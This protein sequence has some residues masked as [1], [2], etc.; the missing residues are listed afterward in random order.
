MPSPAENA[1]LLAN[2]ALRD[3]LV[4][5]FSVADA[6]GS[7][8]ST[9]VHGSGGLIQAA[10]LLLTAMVDAT[11]RFEAFVDL[12]GAVNQ[13]EG[14]VSMQTSTEFRQA[15]ARTLESVLTTV[16]ANSMFTPRFLDEVLLSAEGPGGKGQIPDEELRTELHEYIRRWRALRSD[17]VSDAASPAAAAQS[18]VGRS[19]AD[20]DVVRTSPVRAAIPEAPSHSLQPSQASQSSDAPVLAAQQ[21]AGRLDSRVMHTVATALESV[22]L[23]VGDTLRV[24]TPGPGVAALRGVGDPSSTATDQPDRPDHSDPH[25]QEVGRDERSFHLSGVTPPL[26]QVTHTEASDTVSTGTPGVP[27]ED[28]PPNVPL[29]FRTWALPTYE[30]VYSTFETHVRDEPPGLLRKTAGL[31]CS[32]K[33]LDYFLSAFAR[34]VPKSVCGAPLSLEAAFKCTTCSTDNYAVWCAD[35]FDAALHEGHC[36]RLIFASGLCDCGYSQT[37]DDTGFCREHYGNRCQFGLSDFSDSPDSPD[38]PDREAFDA[39]SSRLSEARAQYLAALRLV[40]LDTFAG[41]ALILLVLTVFV[42]AVP[43]SGLQLG[44]A[45]YHAKLKAYEHCRT[46]I[47]SVFDIVFCSA[48]STN[49]V[50]RKLIARLLISPYDEA[51][52][53][54]DICHHR[55]S[56]EHLVGLMDTDVCSAALSRILDVHTLITTPPPFSA[57]L[58]SHEFLKPYH[59][60]I[61]LAPAPEGSVVWSIRRSLEHL[62][63]LAGSLE[64]EFSLGMGLLFSGEAPVYLLFCMSLL[65]RLEESWISGVSEK[66]YGTGI[67]RIGK[68]AHRGDDFSSGSEEAAADEI[69][70]EEITAEEWPSRRGI[71]PLVE[72]ME[73]FTEAVDSQGFQK[74]MTFLCSGLV[75]EPEYRAF[76]MYIEHW[77][78]RLESLTSFYPSSLII[79]PMPRELLA[80]IGAQ[81]AR[82]ELRQTM[83]QD[84]VKAMIVQKTYQISVTRLRADAAARAVLLGYRLPQAERPAYDCR[85]VLATMYDEGYSMLLDQLSLWPG[86][87][88][89][90]FSQMVGNAADLL[91]FIPPQRVFETAL[92]SL[93]SQVYNTIAIPPHRETDCIT[94]FL[95]MTSC[96]LASLAGKYPVASEV[97]QRYLGSASALATLARRLGV[98]ASVFRREV[99]SEERRDIR[100]VDE[101]MGTPDSTGLDGLL[102]TAPGSP[103]HPSPGEPT[104]Y[105][106]QLPVYLPARSG[107]STHF[108]RR[109][110]VLRLAG[111]NSPIQF[112]GKVLSMSLAIL[113][114]PLACLA[115][116]LLLMQFSAGVNFCVTEG[117]HI[118]NASRIFHNAYSLITA[119]SSFT[120]NTLYGIWLSI[121]LG[122]FPLPGAG[123]ASQS[124][125]TQQQSKEDIDIAFVQAAEHAAIPGYYRKISEPILSVDILGRQGKVGSPGCQTISTP[126]EL[127]YNIVTSS[128]SAIHILEAVDFD[129]LKADA[130]DLLAGGSRNNPSLL[131]YPLFNPLGSS[132]A[133]ALG[134][135]FSRYV[136][137]VPVDLRDRFLANYPVDVVQRAILHAPGSLPHVAL[138]EAAR[139]L[140]IPLLVVMKRSLLRIA[141]DHFHVAQKIRRCGQESEIAHRYYRMSI[142]GAFGHPH[143]MDDYFLVQVCLLAAAQLDWE[144]VSDSEGA[145]DTAVG[146][147]SM[148]NPDGEDSPRSAASQSESSLSES[149]QGEDSSSETFL[150][151][152]EAQRKFSLQ[153][154]VLYE[155]P[156]AGQ[157]LSFLLD[158]IHD[159]F[160]AVDDQTGFVEYGFVRLILN[161]ICYLHTGINTENLLAQLV[162]P[163]FLTGN[164]TVLLS[165]LSSDLR[166]L[167]YYAEGILEHLAERIAEFVPPKIDPSEMYAARSVAGVYRLTQTGLNCASI[168]SPIYPVDGYLNWWEEHLKSQKLPARL[169]PNLLPWWENLDAVLWSLPVSSQGA[170]PGPADPET[171]QIARQ[172]V[173]A[174]RPM[175]ERFRIGLLSS[176]KFSDVVLRL[177]EKVVVPVL[178]DS[179]LPELFKP[180]DVFILL[181]AYS[182]LLEDPICGFVGP[183]LEAVS[184]S[185]VETYERRFASS[186]GSFVLSPTSTLLLAQIVA[187]A[188][189][190]Y[191][192]S[193]PGRVSSP[194]GGPNEI[195]N[196]SQQSAASIS[197][198]TRRLLRERLNRVLTAKA[199]RR[200]SPDESLA[201]SREDTA[202]DVVPAPRPP[203]SAYSQLLLFQ[204]DDQSE[205]HSGAR[206]HSATL[207][208][209]RSHADA[210]DAPDAPDAATS[211]TSAAVTAVGPGNL[212]EPVG[213]AIAHLLSS[214]SGRADECVVCHLP[215]A[216]MHPVSLAGFL[217][218]HI[219]AGDQEA[220]L[221]PG[222]KFHPWF[223]NQ[224]GFSSACRGRNAA[225]TEVALLSTTAADHLGSPEFLAQQ[226][227]VGMSTLISKHLNMI[228]GVTGCVLSR[229]VM[230]RRFNRFPVLSGI[231]DGSY[232]VFRSMAFATATT[233]RH[234]LH[235]KCESGNVL[236]IPFSRCD[237]DQYYCPVC[238]KLRNIEIPLT[239]SVYLAFCHAYGVAGGVQADFS[240]D[241]FRIERRGFDGIPGFQAAIRQAISQGVPSLI[242]LATPRELLSPLPSGVALSS[243]IADQP[244]VRMMARSYSRLLQCLAF[245]SPVIDAE[246]LYPAAE[247]LSDFAS[248]FEKL[249]V[250]TETA[251]APPSSSLPDDILPEQ[252]IIPV[253]SSLGRILPTTE[254]G[255]A[256]ILHLRAIIAW[257]CALVDCGVYTLYT[258]LRGACMS[259]FGVAS[260]EA[261][262]S[263]D[264]GGYLLEMMRAASGLFLQAKQLIYFCQAFVRMG[265]FHSR[266]SKDLH[267]VRAA[268]RTDSKVARE[269]LQLLTRYVV[270]FGADDEFDLN[271]VDSLLTTF[272]NRFNNANY[273]LE[274]PE[275]GPA[276]FQVDSLA[277]ALI[278]LI[279]ICDKAARAGRISKEDILNAGSLTTFYTT[280]GAM[281]ERELEALDIG[282]LGSDLGDQISQEKI[283]SLYSRYLQLSAFC[284]VSKILDEGVSSVR[285]LLE[286]LPPAAVAKYSRSLRTFLQDNPFLPHGLVDYGMDYLIKKTTCAACSTPANCGT[287]ILTFQKLEP[288]ANMVLRC[289]LC[290]RKFCL[291]CAYREL[292]PEGPLVPLDR[293]DDSGASL[294]EAQVRMRNLIGIPSRIHIQ[295]GSE[296]ERSSIEVRK[297]VAIAAFCH[298]SRCSIPAAFFLP[299]YNE[300]LFVEGSGFVYT[301]AGPFLD[302]QFEP[303]IDLT[304][305]ASWTRNNEL[306]ESLYQMLWMERCRNLGV[307]EVGA[308]KHQTLVTYFALQ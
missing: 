64:N 256:C 274:H 121:I 267:A 10:G 135:L 2:Y 119:E 138:A 95:L 36:Y 6:L 73:K 4:R 286:K 98:S 276:A 187:R 282:T 156:A 63:G 89:Y 245:H 144:A 148:G 171:E 170:V 44:E 22:G 97:G 273:M 211:V 246:H 234:V 198:K 247:L 58:Y 185:V 100:G 229:E 292:N 302:R 8:S 108:L 259:H 27:K 250:G 75:F 207:P 177:I 269:Y 203:G 3:S 19:S 222:P 1:C 134:A 49:D 41:V 21:A 141:Y 56:L 297:R 242:G 227:E 232:D 136:Y 285:L 159:A 189:A 175:L 102:T 277:P 169:P 254:A 111:Q 197:S 91:N 206:D 201:T 248:Y 167:P 281:S 184:R 249:R 294:S 213:S 106:V 299:A 9:P 200:D 14:G 303:V 104:P 114:S 279:R 13:T 301:Q 52:T 164:G 180:T 255:K 69:V 122:D 80:D 212:T 77:V 129:V 115:Y 84:P 237:Q 78:M 86:L 296:H 128:L 53:L 54:G 50:S 20:E 81:F 46:L 304:A 61:R 178:R 216:V 30:S 39:Q 67:L 161:V 51:A 284:K 62:P 85:L 68:L 208:R 265:S 12:L 34:R 70:S 196:S 191:S 127:C 24:A 153:T 205:A 223:Q 288:S 179:V 214:F 142:T 137:G 252:V 168:Y 210:P 176:K 270:L 117:D 183:S 174:L 23:H 140:D 145:S 130:I 99:M 149:C 261:S 244:E 190:L 33:L 32:A 263:K 79:N 221:P 87:R 218:V 239:S 186:D 204:P 124:I 307:S 193:I 29:P 241:S 155:H 38:S 158:S 202:D 236:F 308:G 162:V 251:G 291:Q 192:I 74:L 224:R 272:T 243:G 31:P 120:R 231:T 240:V 42:A 151:P 76:L 37:M 271:H 112:W 25:G 165:G 40:D 59:S 226:S 268:M 228:E 88:I 163:R 17:G 295:Q 123:S 253:R 66:V 43:L 94:F 305:S 257:M 195:Q 173:Q 278:P 35:C 131:F 5:L 92:H 275:F 154:N 139:L 287:V 133:Q 126:D 172:N 28:Y 217:G 290:G 194:H 132:L 18:L 93:N 57:G 109:Q 264:Q 182:M 96:G 45:A 235:Q 238:R 103:D 143:V 300:I 262:P 298:A 105:F 16:I 280:L 11:V 306:V 209:I 147:Q 146:L 7:S 219:Q 101:P 125:G 225:E 71:Q 110:L 152:T 157:E 215:T 55:L 60:A 188:R 166:S 82:L 90:P 47:W 220:E 233:C 181:H 150:T 258:A 230:N 48:T 72:L 83:V 26:H 293:L 266:A 199:A 260:V 118:A 65:S 116:T 289:L 107:I 113:R 160:L 283:S 15:F